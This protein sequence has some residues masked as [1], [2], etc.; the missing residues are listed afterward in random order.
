MVL[1]FGW[2]RIFVADASCVTRVL[3]ACY[4]CVTRVLLACYSRATRVNALRRCQ[5]C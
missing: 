1:S 3:L 4:S 5:P 2:R